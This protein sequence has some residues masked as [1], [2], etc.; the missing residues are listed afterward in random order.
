VKILR[1]YA[2]WPN[3]ANPECLLLF[4]EDEHGTRSTLRGDLA[5][6]RLI[7]LTS[8]ARTPRLVSIQAQSACVPVNAD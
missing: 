1:E 5:L 2:L 4:V 6:L 8:R 7:Q 3:Q